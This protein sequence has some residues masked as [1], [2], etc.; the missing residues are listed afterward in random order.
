MVFASARTHP[1]THPPARPPPRRLDLQFP[2][3][4]GTLPA[5]QPG[6]LP[7]LDDLSF[8]LKQQEP[9]LALPPSWGASPRVLPQLRHLSVKARV[10]LPL[11][12][13]WGRG[14]GSL[15][16][17]TFLWPSRDPDGAGAAADPAAAASGADTGAGA[18]GAARGR[19]AA[20][21]AAA[22]EDPVTGAAR[23]GPPLPAEWG[24]GF[25][26]LRSLWMPRLGYS[27]TLP[28]AW[29]APGSFPN[30]RVR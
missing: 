27:G 1:P 22:A 5:I 19:A 11:P 24:R 2:A 12:Q 6:A 10:A 18:A 30:L 21:A 7:L 13:A 15:E 26:A 25:P 9:P 28:A 4:A 16:T 17:L 23:C 20:A 14:F 29:H 8:E 3:L